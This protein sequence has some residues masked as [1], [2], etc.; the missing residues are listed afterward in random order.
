MKKVDPDIYIVAVGA[1]GEWD[2][3]ILSGSAE[4][5]DYI[6]EHFYCQEGPGIL[7]HIAQVPSHIKRISQAHGR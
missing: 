6:S 2:E 3:K 7:A 5:M 1:V 4:H